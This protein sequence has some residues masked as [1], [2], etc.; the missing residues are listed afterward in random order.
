M[1]AEVI[2]KGAT[3]PAMKLGIPLVP[4][5]VLFGSGML[6]IIWG[7]ILLSWWIAAGVLLSFVPALLWMRWVTARDDQRFR[8]MFVALKLR[9]H[10]HNRRFWHAR[11]YSPT[12]YRGAL[13][14]WHL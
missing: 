9:L 2:Y 4:L 14:A 3:R 11:S 6:L 13:D 10:D 8:Q 1:Q 7:G 5:V 12:L